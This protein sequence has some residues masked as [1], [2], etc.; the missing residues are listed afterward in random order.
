MDME[1]KNLCLRSN[2]LLCSFHNKIWS[3]VTVV[4]FVGLCLVGVWMMT[5]LSVVLVENF[6]EPAQEKKTEVKQET[7]N[8]SNTQQFEDNQGDLPE[9]A[10]KREI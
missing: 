4:L 8:E 2:L 1:S 7:N 6:D 5:S 10:T 3:T 9:D